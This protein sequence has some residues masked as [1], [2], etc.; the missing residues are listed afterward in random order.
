MPLPDRFASPQ[1]LPFN[2]TA[3]AEDFRLESPD[4]DPGG[5]GAWVLLRGNELVVTDTG[6]PALP[7]GPVSPVA[8]PDREPVYLGSYRGRPAGPWRSPA[9]RRCRPDGAPKVC[10]RPSRFCRRRCCPSAEPPARFCTGC[11]AAATAIA[12]GR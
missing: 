3:L 12:A 2:S 7:E 11:A 6:D 8:A 5:A 4:R 9:R 10:W 1:N